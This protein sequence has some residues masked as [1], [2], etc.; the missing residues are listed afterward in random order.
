MTALVQAIVALLTS[1]LPLLEGA[2][3]STTTTLI[4]KIITALISIIPAAVQWAENLVPEIQNIIAVLKSNSNVTPEQFQA[5]EAAEQ[6]IDAAFE[7][8]ATAAGDPATGN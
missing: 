8:A 6:S 5:L 1:L 2:S 3:T 7:A 4:E